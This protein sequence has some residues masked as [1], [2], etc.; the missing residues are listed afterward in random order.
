ML[1]ISIN[2]VKTRLLRAR[3]KLRDQ[4]APILGMEATPQNYLRSESNN[5]QHSESPAAAD[6]TG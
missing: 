4:V 3:L 1:G 2:C 5:Q 6:V